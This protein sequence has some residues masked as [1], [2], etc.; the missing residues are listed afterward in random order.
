MCGSMLT[1]IQWDTIGSGIKAI[2]LGHR[3]PALV[4]GL[5]VMSAG[6]TLKVIGKETT[7]GYRMTTTRTVSGT[8]TFAREDVAGARARARIDSSGGSNNRSTIEASTGKRYTAC[9]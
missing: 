3:M 6:N 1:G 2:G 4:G 9:A 8:G 5:P 7:D